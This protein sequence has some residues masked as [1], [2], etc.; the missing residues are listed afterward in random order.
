MTSGNA[1]VGGLLVPLVMPMRPDG[2]LDPDSYARHARRVLDAG[3]RGFWVN[4]SSGDFHAIGEDDSIETVV[5]ARA[6]A[7]PDVP[8]IAHVGDTATDRSVRK[9]RRSMDAGAD[10]VAAITPYYADYTHEELVSHH[11]RIAEASGRSVFLYQHP[12]TGKAPLPVG[13]IIGMVKDGVCGGIKESGVDI[14]YFE[15]L[16]TCAREHDCGLR[17]FH[18][19]GGRALETLGMGSS[20]IITVLANLL[21]GTCASLYRC[22][23]EDDLEQARRHQDRVDELARALAASMPTRSTAAPAVAAIKYVLSEL[24][25]HQHDLVMDPLRPLDELERSALRQQ[26]LPMA[27]EELTGN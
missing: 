15:E 7:G 22:V 17:T 13:T 3:A 18:G 6:V 25:I 5:I 26:V 2:C 4:G 21:P 9:A 14:D 1:D 19:A 8:I 24:G 20:G 11:A 16:V 23:V 10:H 12:A 27:A